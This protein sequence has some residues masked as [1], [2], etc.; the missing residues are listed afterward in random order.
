M[1]GLLDYGISNIRSVRKAFVHLGVPTELVNGPAAVS[2][3]PKLVLPGVGAFAPGMDGLRRYNLTDSINE[4]VREGTPLL[5]ICLGMQFL[6]DYSLEDGQHQGL[7][8]IP[9][10]VTRFP[11]MDLSVPHIGWNKLLIHQESPLLSGIEPG[12]YGY[13]VHSYV[14][15]PADPEAVIA[16]TNYGEDFAAVVSQGNVFG[17]QFHPEKSQAVGLSI[18]KNF[19]SL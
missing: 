8:L 18:L 5:G 12:D 19:A 2:R 10:V 17:V 6:F 14:C 15:R 11:H 4:V 9:G 16:Y 1:I 13:F 7:G 3:Y